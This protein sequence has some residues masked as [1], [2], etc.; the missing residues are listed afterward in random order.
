M[1]D[2]TAS[3]AK[4]TPGIHVSVTGEHFNIARVGDVLST[5]GQIVRVFERKGSHY[6][7]AEQL[8][9]ANH[10][11]PIALFRRTSIYAVRQPT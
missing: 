1:H 10:R 9:V 8:V 7:E 4:P 3:Y 2:A 6:L 5:S 11:T